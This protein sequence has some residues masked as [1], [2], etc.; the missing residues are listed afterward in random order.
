MKSRDVT[1]LYNELPIGALV[2][3]IPDRLPK[4]P[5]GRANA[6]T[7]NAWA[8]AIPQAPT[9]AQASVTSHN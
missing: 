5:K 1:A 8:P 9:V 2:Q 3:I 4:L 6:A 7:V